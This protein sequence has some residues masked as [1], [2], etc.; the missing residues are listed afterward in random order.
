MKPHNSGVDLTRAW[1]RTFKTT[2]RRRPLVLHHLLFGLN[3][4]INLDLGGVAVEMTTEAARPDLQANLDRINPVLEGM[5]EAQARAIEAKDKET[6]RR[7]A[8]VLRP[9]G[10]WIVPVLLRDR[11]WE[12]DSVPTGLSTVPPPEPGGVMHRPA[13]HE[14]RRW[15]PGEIRPGQWQAH[16]PVLGEGNAGTGGGTRTHT[17]HRAQRIFVPLQFSLVGR[18]LDFLFTVSGRM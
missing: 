16:V 13:R 2:A 10:P 8:R 9:G 3:A 11:L 7:T 12:T 5:I 4:H 15:R 14:D 6:A 17:G 1:T 18:G